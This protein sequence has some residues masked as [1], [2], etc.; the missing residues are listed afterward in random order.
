[1][2]YN[3]PIA[4]ACSGPVHRPFASRYVRQS[5][6]VTHHPPR[7]VL[8]PPSILDLP[9]L[10]SSSPGEQYNL[11]LDYLTVSTPILTLKANPKARRTPKSCPLLCN[12]A[13]ECAAEVPWSSS[14]FL[15]ETCMDSSSHV[16]QVM[17]DPVAL[18]ELPAQPCGPC[19]EA[20]HSLDPV[21]TSRV[22]P[23]PVS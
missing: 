8:V 20:H 5:V 14:E 1:M 17:T 12:H 10:R 22:Y 21:W 4:A 15:A 9:V 11:L 16:L 18:L 13:A 3:L 6:R 23:I 19:I 2:S 7:A